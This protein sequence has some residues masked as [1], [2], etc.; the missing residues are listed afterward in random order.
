MGL[1]A[2]ISLTEI[3]FL[4]I[5]SE[6]GAAIFRNWKNQTE[7]KIL[8]STENHRWQLMADLRWWRLQCNASSRAH[9]LSQNELTTWNVGENDCNSTRSV[10]WSVAG[11]M[12][13][14]CGQLT[15]SNALPPSDR[16]SCCWGHVFGSWYQNETKIQTRPSWWILKL[17]QL[18]S[19]LKSRPM[20]VPG[21]GHVHRC[22]SQPASH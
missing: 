3:C 4:F 6:T 10:K 1:T 19:W 21:W 2:A 12:Q 8:S 16:P 13:L 15:R 20:P 9:F 18:T 17:W 11:R 22:L 7:I 14:L 5:W